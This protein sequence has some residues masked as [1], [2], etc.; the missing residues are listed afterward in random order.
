MH[1][2]SIKATLEAA[3]FIADEPL[4]IDRL[5]ELFEDDQAVTPNIIREALATLQKD[6]DGHG[7]E[8]CEV[9][10]GYRF[11]V[12]VD[13]VPSL[14]KWLQERPEKYS[15]SLL[16]TLALIAYRQPITRADIEQV[17][18]VAVSTQ[19]IKTLMAREWIKITGH[20]DVP[21]KPA[22]YAT[23]KKFLDYF[24]LKSLAD[25]PELLNSQ[26]DEGAKQLE[27]SLEES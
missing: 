17:R 7:I 24:D 25:L 5:L 14:S 16:E 19:T 18:G 8:L 4:S 12:R 9:A 3:I 15:R 11:Q 6:Y 23:T 13:V 10:S 27:L 2:N 22:L 26:E 21:G 20:R 1:S